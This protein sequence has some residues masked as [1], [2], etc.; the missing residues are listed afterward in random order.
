MTDWHLDSAME[1]HLTKASLIP[2]K[3]LKFLW[4]GIIPAGTITI[5]AGRGAAGK[6]TICAWLAGQVAAGKLPGAGHGKPANVLMV[7]AN[8]DAWDSVM[9]PRLEAA[10]VNLDRVYRLLA[11]GFYGPGML[12]F[13][14]DVG[15]LEA[16]I[17][18][19][20][21]RLVII[22]PASSIFYGNLDRREEVRASVD[23]LAGVAERTGAALLIVHHFA[24]GGGNARDKLTGSVAWDDAARSLLTI[25]VDPQNPNERIVSQQKNTH[26][27]LVDSFKFTITGKEIKFPDGTKQDYPRAEFGGISARSVQ[28]AI[29]ETYQHDA[30]GDDR[31]ELEELISSCLAS[32][33]VNP[34]RVFKVAN[35]AGGWSKDQVKRAKRK[36]GIEARKVDQ[37]EW[38][39]M[40]AEQAVEYDRER[41]ESS[42]IEQ[43]EQPTLH[44]CTVAQ[45]P[46]DQQV[47]SVHEGNSP[48]HLQNAAHLQIE[49]E[50]LE[51]P[52]KPAIVPKIEWIGTSE[53]V[54]KGVTKEEVP[55]MA[56]L[57][58]GGMSA[59]A[60]TVTVIWVAGAVALMA[61]ILI[62]RVRDGN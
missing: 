3:R 57:G 53:G 45:A 61:A 40:T 11:S 4:N 12:S 2:K 8:E 46:A 7:T 42:L 54:N 56:E 6:G 33:P 13:P 55:V 38:L 23:P 62:W 44:T 15:L 5:F 49:R 32:G 51:N 36:I 24:K 28:D 19:T 14:R 30:D 29:N 41:Y 17:K 25:S 47:P 48:A 59:A 34:E 60:L 27:Q 21:A 58:S 26:N 9:I 10:E 39:W 52:I 43:T 35:S 18:Q 37:F 16:A 31:A 22:D 1:P 20:G 50:N